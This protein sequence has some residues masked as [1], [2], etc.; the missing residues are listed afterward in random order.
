MGGEIYV[1]TTIVQSPILTMREGAVGII[2]IHRPERFNAMDVDTARDFRK[3]GMQMA[4]DKSVRAVILRGTGKVF[5]SGADLKYIRDHGLTQDFEYLKPEGG[6]VPKAGYGAC[7]KE[8]LEYIHSTISE[9]KRAPKPFIAAVNGI[10][11]A[12]GFGIAM[13]CDLV[14][15]SE[16]ATFEWA[17]HKTALTGAESSTFFLPKLIGLRKALELMFLNPRLSAEEAKQL[18]LVTEVFPD[19]LLDAEVMEFAQR[20]AKGPTKSYGVAKA[21]IHRAANCDQLD[22]HLD[23]ELDELARAADGDEFA[24]GIRAF[25]EKRTPNF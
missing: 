17:Y 8:I 9:I 3:A 6:I 20:L 10:A 12:G 24:E 16:H 7:F 18:G 11:A 2:E 23:Q 21:L 25:F 5:C 14:F 1:S 15:A 4:R 13:A 22:F 19:A